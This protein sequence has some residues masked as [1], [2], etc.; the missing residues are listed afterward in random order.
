MAIEIKE[1][2]EVEAPIAKVWDFLL[3]AE[4]VAACMPG[5]SLDEVIDAKNYIGSIKLRVGAVTA[6]YKGKI[7]FTKVDL[8]NYC[9]EMIAEGKDT[10]GG[11]AK[12]TITNRLRAISATRTEVMTDSSIEIAG[13]IMQV[14]RGMIEGVSKQLFQKFVKSVQARLETAAPTV[15]QAGAAASG[16]AGALSTPTA[17]QLPVDEKELRVIPLLLATLWA[18]IRG[19]FQKLFKN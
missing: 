16:G 18:A 1:K 2:F 10:S 12:G 8:A 19:F 14:G 17:A 5:A 6:S 9:V 15:A 13:R 3:N 11:T 4:N 7:E